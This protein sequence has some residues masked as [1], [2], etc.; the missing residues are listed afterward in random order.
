MRFLRWVLVLA[1]AGVAAGV[2]FSRQP[3]G[4][5]TETFVEIPSG[6]G[7]AGI[8][9]RLERAGVIRSRFL[10]EAYRKYRGGTLRAGEYRFDHAAVL[11]E[12]YGRLLKGDVYTKTVSVPEGFNLFDIAHAVEAAGLGTAADFLAAANQDT[13][14]I[15]A[16]SPHARSL[17]GFLYPDTYKFSR[18]ATPRQI[19]QAMVARFRA[20]GLKLGLLSGGDGERTVT[21]A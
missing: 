18:H 16:Y 21:V 5:K 3:Y 14:L 13:A 19:L 17:E 4:P 6:T 9:V 15:Q 7:S 8:A 20:E 11:P 12:V 10:F 2:Y 1:L